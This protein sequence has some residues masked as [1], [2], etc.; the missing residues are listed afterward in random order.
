MK[1]GQWWK[2]TVIY[3]TY[4]DKFAGNFRNFEKKLGY[5]ENLGIN[6]VHILPFF[7][8]PGADEGY[9]VTDYTSVRNDLGSLKDIES[10][11]TEASK[12]DIRIIIDLVLNHTSIQ[13]PWFKKALSSPKSPK[14]NYYLWSSTGKEFP[15]AYNPFS[16]LKLKNWIF[17]PTS[18]Q[19]YYST[20]LPEQADLNWDNPEVEEEILKV[21]DFWTDVGVS[22]FRLDATSFL[23]KRSGTS[24]RHLPETHAI[25]KRIRKHLKNRRSDAILLGEIHAPIETMSSY[26]GNGDE[27]HMAYHFPFMQQA[28]LSLAREDPLMVKNVIAVSSNIPDSCRWAIFLTSH[29]EI[30]LTTMGASERAEVISFLDPEN[31]WAFKPGKSIS[32]RLASALKE[33]REKI[34]GAFELLF[35]SPGSPIIYYGSEIGMLNAK[36]SKPPRD[37]RFYLRGPFEWSRAEREMKDPDSILNNVKRMIR[38]RKSCFN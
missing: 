21:M 33:S 15:E 12:Q 13:H 30:T 6:C 9:D 31:K 38:E 5:L 22:G 10:F 34:I 32:M 26:F 25:L 8:S 16:H 11:I 14:R 17:D 1:K 7:P 35:K 4:V 3:E 24:C 36:L 28:F 20:F 29:D 37:T 2:N 18:Q 27:C 19:Y 23:I